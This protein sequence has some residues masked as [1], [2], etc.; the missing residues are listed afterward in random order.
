V[1]LE[2]AASPSGQVTSLLP[3]AVSVVRAAY[4]TAQEQKP[5]PPGSR[6]ETARRAQQAR[7][8]PDQNFGSS[9]TRALGAFFQWVAGLTDSN[10]DNQPDDG[11]RPST[12]IGSRIDTRV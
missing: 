7:A 4:T 6:G 8:A 2:L 9:L 11:S 3:P 10:P 12:T 5:A 1:I